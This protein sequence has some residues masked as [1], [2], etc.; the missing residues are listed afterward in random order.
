[1]IQ[2][3]WKDVLD[4]FI[5][6]ED[7]NEPVY[8]PV[9]FAGMI[10]IVVFSIGVLFW[11]LWSLLVLGGGIVGKIVPALQV[12]LTRKTLQDFGWVGYPYEQGIFEGFIG[13]TLALI[14]TLALVVG[15]WWLFKDDHDTKAE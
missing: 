14:L 1:M 13:N 15:I 11:L 9:H 10:V 4:F 12:L 2:K 6:D 5:D 8:D 7:P 3:L